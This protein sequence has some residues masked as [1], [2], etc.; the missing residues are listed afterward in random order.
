MFT[1]VFATI[2][3]RRRQPESPPVGEQIN[4]MWFAH[5]VELFRHKT[6]GDRRD[7][8][9]SFYTWSKKAQHERAAVACFQ[10]HEAHRKERPIHRGRT[11]SGGCG[12]AAGRL[13]RVGA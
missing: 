7:K 2:A 10:L 1:A 6:G 13:W 9:F 5:N 3:K 8:P 12:C 4:S 11:E